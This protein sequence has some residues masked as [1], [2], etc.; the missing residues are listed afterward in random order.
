MKR[1]NTDPRV[2]HDVLRWHADAVLTIAVIRQMT[3]L[4]YELT[5]LSKYIITKYLAIEKLHLYGKNK[6]TL[7]TSH[8]RCMIS[9]LEIIVQ[10]FV[11]Q[12]NPEV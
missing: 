12:A 10:S 1:H 5:S 11:C 2:S 8:P 7:I 9:K 4:L 3:K 6:Q